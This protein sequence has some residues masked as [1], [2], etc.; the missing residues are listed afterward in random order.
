[1]GTLFHDA[2]PLQHENFV[3]AHDCGQAMRDHNDGTPFSQCS[4]GLLNQRF[5]LGISKSGGFIQ[6]H[7]GRVFQDGPGQGDAL[8]LAARKI[9]PFGAELGVNAFR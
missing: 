1:M 3:R 7:D 9:S 8:L 5:I 2:P 6:H 4:E